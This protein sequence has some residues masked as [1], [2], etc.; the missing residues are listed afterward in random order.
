MSTPEVS[1]L[2]DLPAEGLPQA[3][4]RCRRRNRRCRPNRRLTSLAVAFFGKDVGRAPR[5]PA[6]LNVRLVPAGAATRPQRPGTARWEINFPVVSAARRINRHRTRGPA[7]RLYP[8][9]AVTAVTCLRRRKPEIQA[10][11]RAC[12]PRFT[13]GGPVPDGRTVLPTNCAPP[14]ASQRRDR[15]RRHLHTRCQSARTREPGRSSDAPR[16]SMSSR[17]PPLRSASPARSSARSTTNRKSATAAASR[18]IHDPAANP[19][20]AEPANPTEEIRQE[21]A[22]PSPTRVIVQ[23]GTRQPRRLTRTVTPLGGTWSR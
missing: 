13:P 14:E 3:C 11:T 15:R 19:K 7:E 4:H 18:K 20:P 12:P 16:S 9:S 17:T 5:S 21:V 8:A 6:R 22:H 23:Q 1:I 10:I 2:F